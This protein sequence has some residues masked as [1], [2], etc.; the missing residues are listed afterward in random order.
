MKHNPWYDTASFKIKGKNVSKKGITITLE[1]KTK[2][3][4]AK[5]K[6]S[7]DNKKQQQQKNIKMNGQFLFLYNLL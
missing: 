5:P 3:S 6:K 4:K 1:K 2:Q 7:N